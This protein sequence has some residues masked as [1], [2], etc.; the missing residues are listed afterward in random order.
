MKSYNEYSH[1]SVSMVNLN[2]LTKILQDENKKN[3]IKYVIETGTNIGTGSTRMLAETFVKEDHHPEVFTFEANWRNWKKA[4]KNLKKYNFVKPIWGFSV[5]HKEASQFV[6]EDYALQHQD[7]FPDI[8]IDGGNDPLGFY[9]KELSG[10]F[11][12]TRFKSINYILKCFE[13]K[14][15]NINYSGEDLLRKYLIKYKKE[16]PLIV[17]DSSGAIGFLEFKIVKEIMGND[18]Y[19]LLLDDIHHLKH[20]RSYAEIKQSSEYNILMIDEEG[21]WV[22]AKKN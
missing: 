20:F 15:K 17:L 18:Q 11:G 13:N 10:E 7:E 22:F 4:K 16:L 12:I 6:K 14:D 19:Y 3:K 1:H 2:N 8:F 5:P 9:L 21:G